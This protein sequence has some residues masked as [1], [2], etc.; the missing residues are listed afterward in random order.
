MFGFMDM[1]F[2]DEQRKVENTVINGA[3]IDTARVNDS[4]KPFETAV[5]HPN[6]NGHEWVI[7]ELYDDK[8]EATLG[9]ARWVEAFTGK[10]T[11]S[12]TDVS[13]SEIKRFGV[14]LGVMDEE[15]TFVNE[16]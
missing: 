7:V 1:D 2:D 11:V 14:A 6:I 4:T 5:K 15:D 12:L 9:H 16:N 3:T 8:E 13:T 10:L